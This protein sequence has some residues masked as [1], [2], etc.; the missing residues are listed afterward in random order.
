MVEIW[1]FCIQ[2]NVV[3]AATG[4]PDLTTALPAAYDSPAGWESFNLFADDPKTFVPPGP[5]VARLI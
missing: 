1:P 4:V 5:K 3:S 2:L